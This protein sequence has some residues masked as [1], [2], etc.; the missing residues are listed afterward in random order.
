MAYIPVLNY[1]LQNK[2]LLL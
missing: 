1:Y 2:E